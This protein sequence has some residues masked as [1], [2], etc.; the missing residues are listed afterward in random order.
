MEIDGDL[1]VLG[2]VNAPGL[3]GMKPERIYS[4][5]LNYSNEGSSFIVPNGKLWILIG[6]NGGFVIEISGTPNVQATSMNNAEVWLLQNKEFYIVHT[7]EC[8]MTIFEYSIS[9]SGTDQGM[10][11]IEP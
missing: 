3:G 11:Y 2:S 4:L 5:P 10:D 6:S 7:A 9:G 8:L 1:T